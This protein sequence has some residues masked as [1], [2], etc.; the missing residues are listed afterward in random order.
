MEFTVTFRYDDGDVSAHT[1]LSEDAAKGLATYNLGL[2]SK[3]LVSITIE[4]QK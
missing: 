3:G 2:F 1:G 4:A